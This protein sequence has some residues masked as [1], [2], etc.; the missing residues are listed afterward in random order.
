MKYKT[1]KEWE[2]DKNQAIKPNKNVARGSKTG[3]NANNRMK[4]N[5]QFFGNRTIENQ[6]ETQ[7]RKDINSYKKLIRQ[8]EDKIKNP[9]EYVK[10]WD[11]LRK[12]HQSNLIAHWATEIKTFDKN[13]NDNLTEIE[14]RS[15]DVNK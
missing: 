1:Y 11:N 15:K 13:I 6:T 4:I 5:L 10:K 2:K 12:E 8:H 7:L 9:S 14:K 3:N